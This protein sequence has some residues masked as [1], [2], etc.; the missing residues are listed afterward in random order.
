MKLIYRILLRLSVA[1][2]VLLTAWAIG[3][4]AVLVDEVNDETDDAL[5]AYAE[6]IIRR[7]LAG[8]D[9]PAEDNG[10][11]NS[12]HVRP[13]G[14]D[15]LRSRPAVAYSDEQIFI[16]EMNE[17]EPARTLRIIFRDRYG[18]HHLLTV[19]TPTI[20]KDDLKRAILQLII[21]LYV[22][23]LL[24]ILL[25]N[26]W[27]YSRSM[28]PLHRLLRWF[29]AYTVGRPAAPLTDDT[30]VTE[31]RRLH[32]AVRRHVA[33][34]EQAFEQQKQFIGNAAHELQ[35]PLAAGLGRLELLADST[36]VLSEQQLAEIVRTQQ[37]LRRAVRL[38]R[39]LLFLSKID[40][41]QFPESTDVDL[42]ALIRS[43]EEDLRE[44]YATRHISIHL[45]APTDANVSLRVRMHEALADALVGNLLKNAFVHNHPGGRILIRLAPHTL[46]VANTGH[47]A[48]LDSDR[49]FDRFYQ[50]P[51]RSEGSTGLGL[52][53]VRA[54][55]RLYAIDVRYAFT[56]DGLHTFTLQFPPS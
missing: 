21:T 30:P 39:S 3:C 50:G 2:S 24:T 6:R 32:A 15:E 36:P 54:I 17:T 41:G 51:Q 49:I 33:R 18:D 52:S 19:S 11:N 12:F 37:S 53:I 14:D 1:L 4:Y 44:V 40:N 29:D 31:F 13:V 38:N 42:G 28:R 27:V 56:A 16:P 26:V 22:S 48:A 8:V 55:A 9:L 25:I 23:L 46:S 35:T 45:T 20:D 5:E 10:T 43:H 34:T 7:M 47:P